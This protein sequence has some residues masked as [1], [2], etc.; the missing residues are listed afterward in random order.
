MLEYEISQALHVILPYIGGSLCVTIGII[1]SNMFWK[2][3][4]HRYAKTEVVETLEYQKNKIAYQDEQIRTMK[5]VIS[6]LRGRLKIAKKWSLKI[7]EEV[8]TIGGIG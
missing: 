3:R 1:I 7:A 5:S 6:D 8:D 2:A 4:I